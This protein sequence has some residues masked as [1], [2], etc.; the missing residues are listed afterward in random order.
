MTFG[1]QVHHQVGIRRLHRLTN[2]LCIREVHPL[3]HMAV[4]SPISELAQHFLNRGQI[5][6]VAHLVEVE[7]DRLALLEQAPHHGPTDKSSP[8]CHQYPPPGSQQL[9]S[10][11]H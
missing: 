10:S 5:A 9:C 11:R 8:S 7:H 3:Q 1:R 4:L 2:G 6:G